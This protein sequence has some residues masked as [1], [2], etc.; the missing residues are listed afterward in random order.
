MFYDYTFL[1]S[2]KGPSCSVWRRTSQ[3]I[4]LPNTLKNS[5]NTAKR[6]KNTPYFRHCSH[7]DF[8]WCTRYRH[9]QICSH[10][11]SVH[12]YRDLVYY[13]FCNGS[14]TVQIGS[15]I[16]DPESDGTVSSCVWSELFTSR[17]FGGSSA[18]HKHVAFE[19]RRF[20]RK[21]RR[22]IATI[23]LEWNICCA[24]LLSSKLV[25]QHRIFAFEWVWIDF[26]ALL[27]S[28]SRG[29]AYAGS[30]HSKDSWYR[31]SRQQVR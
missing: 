21:F 7:D 19:L 4:Q 8:A 11:R 12:S 17:G 13:Q 22:L 28:W 5:E 15:I 6:H 3:A 20:M 10:Q 2:C 30:V 23:L 29:T 1:I 14:H 16:I 27:I 24:A 9:F 26:D 18:H 31:G 25:S